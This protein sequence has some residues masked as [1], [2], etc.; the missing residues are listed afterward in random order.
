M[1]GFPVAMRHPERFAR[2]IAAN[3]GI[4]AGGAQ[5][6]A[7]AVARLQRPREGA[8]DRAAR[9]WLH[10]ERT[11][12]RG[13]ARLRRALPG[14]ELPGRRPLL[15]APDPAPAGQPRSKAD[16]RDLEAARALDEALPH[17]VRRPRPDLEG[18]GPRP[19]SSACPARRASRTSCCHR[20][21]T[22]CKRI[23][24]RRSQRTST[25]SPGRAVVSTSPQRSS[26]S[27][28][29]RFPMR[30]RGRH[31]SSALQPVP[32][33]AASTCARSMAVSAAYA[34]SGRCTIQSVY[35]RQSSE[36]FTSR[37][38]S[39]RAHVEVRGF[40]ELRLAK[41]CRSLVARA[42]FRRTQPLEQ[43]VVG[44]TCIAAR[45]LDRCV[46]EEPLEVPFRYAAADRV[47]RCA[48]CPRRDRSSGARHAHAKRRRR[49]ASSQLRSMRVSPEARA[50]RSTR[51]RG[52]RTPPA[53]GRP[54][55][56]PSGRRPRPGR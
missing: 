19:S 29:R 54:S 45:G 26:A 25:P 4:P 24:P 13:E 28:L 52:S 3:T 51:A 10:G 31:A 55:A 21:I 30:C 1:I 22:S 38:E 5:P 47:G 46:P 23:S 36:S 50:R 41:A 33:S 49:Y 7:P 44:E 15:P 12:R 34:S 6:G 35:G 16:A 9:P 43:R 20:R 32:S 53:A 14:W 56:S 2:L 27:S 39:R 37:F 11:Q 17:R 18:S 42:L 48:S 40:V 8:A